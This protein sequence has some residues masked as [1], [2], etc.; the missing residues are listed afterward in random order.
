MRLSETTQTESVISLAL[1]VA[2]QR[3][4][5]ELTDVNATVQDVIKEFWYMK[6]KDVIEAIRSGSLG[7]Y[8][9]TFKLNTQE[10]CL[11]IR[12]YQESKKTKL[13]L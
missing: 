8:G 11:W 13:G 7:K 10:V 1:V 2:M 6:T 5:Q 4:D 12:A 3:V 9:K